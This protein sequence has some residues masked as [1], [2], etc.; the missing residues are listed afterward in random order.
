LPQNLLISFTPYPWDQSK[1]VWLVVYETTLH[2][3]CR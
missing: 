3:M 2:A 1:P